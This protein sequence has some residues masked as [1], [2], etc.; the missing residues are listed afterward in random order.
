MR[1][2]WLISLSSPTY[3]AS[4]C[5][6]HSRN[7]CLLVAVADVCAEADEGSAEDSQCESGGLGNGRD[8]LN[9][10]A[11]G[12]EG[13]CRG[14]AAVSQQPFLIASAAAEM[15]GAENKS[16][17]ASEI[18]PVKGGNGDVNSHVG[19]VALRRERQYGS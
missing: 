5:L 15:G 12:K 17:S 3:Q 10:A 11:S 8:I 13:D 19:T 7:D 18:P 1:G 4:E 16:A 2:R 9:N 14:D 6:L